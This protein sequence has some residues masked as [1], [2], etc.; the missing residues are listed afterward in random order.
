MAVN[1]PSTQYDAMKTAG[2]W[3]L[4]H[5]LLGGTQTMRLAGK[6]WLPQETEEKDKNY[7]VRKNRSFLYNAYSDTIEKFVARPFSRP[8]V[9][10]ILDVEA[11]E[12]FISVSENMD[13]EGQHLQEF[14]KDYLRALIRWGVTHAFVDYPEIDDPDSVTKADEQEKDLQPINRVIEAPE[15]IGWKTEER[16]NGSQ[17]LSEV[18]ISE[19]YVEDEDDWTQTVYE[20]IRVIRK[21]S[22]ELWRRKK[23]KP[24]EKNDREFEKVD[25]GEIKI[26]G[27]ESDIIPVVTAYTQ[28]TGLMMALPPLRELGWTNLEHWQSASDQKNILR[29]DRFGILMGSGFTE[30]EM[31]K[32]IVVAPTQAIMSENPDATMNRVETNGKPAENGWKDL[33]HIVERLEVLGLQP[34][35]QR[36]GNVKATGMQI[37]ES[38]SRSQI[39]SWIDATNRAMKQVIWL[40]LQWMGYDVDMEKIEFKIY[41]DFVFGSADSKNVDDIIKARQMGEISHRTFIKEMQRFGR[42]SDS[43]DADEEVSRAQADIGRGVEIFGDQREQAIARAATQNVDTGEG[44]G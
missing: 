7:E 27:E 35:I 36:Y 18:R 13:G 37:N 26:G 15:L 44:I 41:Q 34:M 43:V 28:K 20:Q 1:T 14:A 3:D 10:D 24:N 5:D 38:K 30:K 33:E 6:R 11:K 29:F 40:N 12:A 2:A 21:D 16:E 39:E 31:K 25:D 19:I 17:E 8:I 42:L 32:G 23:A 9:W 22:W 4:L